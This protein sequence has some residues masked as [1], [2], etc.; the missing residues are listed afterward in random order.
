MT[1]KI[2]QLEKKHFELTG[3]YITADGV[4]YW[5][6][7]TVQKFV[8]EVK[9]VVQNQVTQNKELICPCCGSEK[10]YRTEAMHCKRCAVTT[11]I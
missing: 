11:E 2:K 5:H 4:R 10:T 1:D 3:N 8:Q 6:E 9:E 7:K